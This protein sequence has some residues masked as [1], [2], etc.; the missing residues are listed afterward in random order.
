MLAA[1]Y[2]LERRGEWKGGKEEADLVNSNWFSIQP[3]LVHNPCRVLCVL[4]TDELHEAIALV[5]LRD[6]IFR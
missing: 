2:I 3:Y 5:R 4:L 1:V 6:S